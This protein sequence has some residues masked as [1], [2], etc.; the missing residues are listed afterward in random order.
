MCVC[1]GR[2]VA[3]LPRVTV[4]MV[5]R[6]LLPQQ[7]VW[8]AEEFGSLVGQLFSIN[9]PAGCPAVFHDTVVENQIFTEPH[10][11]SGIVRERATHLH[12]VHVHVHVFK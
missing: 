6:S 12:H 9:R 4:F 11:K 7:R 2:S 5:T 10:Q 8:L 1:K 3:V